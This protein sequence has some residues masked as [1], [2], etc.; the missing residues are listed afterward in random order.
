MRLENKEIFKKTIYFPKELEKQL[1]LYAVRTD[2]SFAQLLQNIVIEWA[3]NN[4][5]NQ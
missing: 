4:L 1:K 2:I 5:P 3:D